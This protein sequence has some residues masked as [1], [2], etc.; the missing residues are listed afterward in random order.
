MLSLVVPS[1]VGFAAFYIF[2]LGQFC[3]NSYCSKTQSEKIVN[4]TSGTDRIK[5]TWAIGN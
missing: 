4:N 2:V 3:R 1:L 5:T